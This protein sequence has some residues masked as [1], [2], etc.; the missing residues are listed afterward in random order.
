MESN[1]KDFET[2]LLAHMREAE[3]QAVRV[4]P[5]IAVKV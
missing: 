1:F 2:E 3:K 5:L 4:D